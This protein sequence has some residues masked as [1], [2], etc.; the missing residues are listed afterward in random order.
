MQTEKP[1][2]DQ[3]VFP[4]I[5]SYMIN[6][7]HGLSSYLAVE[8]YYQPHF[9]DGNRGDKGSTEGHPNTALLLPRSTA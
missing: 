5:V 2:E 1:R 8:Y 9:I 3:P 4:G 6:T 7:Y